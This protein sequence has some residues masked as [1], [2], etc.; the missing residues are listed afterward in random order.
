MAS[1]INPY[2]IN[3]NYPVA[4]QDNDSQGF[5]DNFTNLRNNLVFAKAEIEDLQRNAVLKSALSGTSLDNNLDG[6][7]L[8]APQLK[9]WTQS[10]VTETGALGVVDINFT[11]GN[12][13]NITP[14]GNVTLN[15][16]N[17]PN[18][19][20]GSVIV[21]LEITNTAFTVTMPDGIDYI[22]I[23]GYNS[24]NKTITFASTGSYL[25]EIS[26]F[27]R[28]QYV[29]RDL[30]LGSTLSGQ[31]SA[32]SL[33][34]RSSAPTT[35]TA[36]QIAIA[37][38]VS[39]VEG[40][41]PLSKG[42]GVPYAVLYDGE[43]WVGLAS[44]EGANTIAA[45]DDVTLTSP[46]DG[47]I[48]V[49]DA[50]SPAQWKN[51]S[52]VLSTAA[53]VE[54]VDP[55]DDGSVLTYV[56]SQNKWTNQISNPISTQVVTVADPL[57][58]NGT[59]EVFYFDSIPILDTSL[60]KENPITL[61]VNKKYRFLQSDASNAGYQLKFSTVADSLDPSVTANNDYS[62]GVIFATDDNDEVIPPGTAGAYT[63]IEITENTP[64]PL[65]I[66]SVDIDNDSSRTATGGAVPLY[67]NGK[68]KVFTGSEEIEDGDSIDL[69]R[70]ASYFTTADAGTATLAAGIEGQVK[71]LAAVDVAEGREMVVTVTNAA[72]GGNGTITFNGS[73]QTANLM[74]INGKWFCIGTAIDINGLEPDFN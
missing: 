27:N 28:T 1:S 16:V 41:D 40:W 7:E 35:A 60:N 48:L 71:I 13:Y 14:V 36:G 49:Y 70:T 24:V 20:Y 17:F 73:G 38:G 8:V 33:S 66:Y 11:Y 43:S 3:G 37:D 25:F 10:M 22:D 69:N 67:I 61:D 42:T 30:K 65:Y 4:G 58:E 47:N 26:T 34:V 19:G 53:D 63:E 59:Q 46:E 29:V 55:I 23:P 21:W 39:G 32:L 50:E 52:L 12:F 72:W 9:A 62:V 18:S 56:K 57:D 15:F 68:I 51:S 45:L 2:N 6:S 5:R 64:S 74:Y 44:V 31:S 54:L